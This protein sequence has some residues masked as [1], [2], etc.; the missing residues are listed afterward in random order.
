MVQKANWIQDEYEINHAISYAHYAASLP[1]TSTVLA[2]TFVTLK[3]LLHGLL[4][5]S[6]PYGGKRSSLQP[7]SYPADEAA[8]RLAVALLT[9]ILRVGVAIPDKA[10]DAVEQL[11]FY[12]ERLGKM[13]DGGVSPGKS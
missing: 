2:D 9:A 12:A 7:C 4:G 11:E 5:G 10:A 13:A 6:G 8:Q 3:K 1:P